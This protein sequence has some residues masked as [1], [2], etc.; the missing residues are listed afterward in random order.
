MSLM[1]PCMPFTRY[2]LTQTLYKWNETEHTT[3]DILHIHKRQDVGCFEGLLLSRALPTSCHNSRP[4]VLHG[5]IFWK[6]TQYKD[7]LSQTCLDFWTT[8]PENHSFIGL[9]E[10]SSSYHIWCCICAH[11]QHEQLGLQSTSFST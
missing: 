8:P 2:L 3:V 4:L 9:K 10:Q 6:K 7:R 11:A 1:E 5:V